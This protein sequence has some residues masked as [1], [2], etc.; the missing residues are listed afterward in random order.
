MTQT[1][2][3]A[4]D[5]GSDDTVERLGR[6]ALVT[7][8]ILYLVVGVL[9]VQVAN[10]DADAKASQ[11][12]A[13]ESI[14]HQSHGRILLVVLL[15][16]LVAHALWR[17]ALAVRGEE[18]PD[19]DSKSVAK[20]VANVGRSLVYVSFSV[21]AA[22]IVLS[23]GGNGGGGGGGGKQEQESTATVLS[24][25]GG[26]WL[27]VGA[28]VVGLGVGVWNVRKVF[29]RSYMEDLDVSRLDRRARRGVEVLGAAGYAA[30]GFAFALVGWFLI[31]AGRQRD[32]GETRS[33][34]AALRELTT[35]SYGPTL[36]LLLA[37]GLVLFGAFRILDGLLRRPTELTHS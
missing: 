17:L 18:G 3:A 30:R 27:V 13:I 32:P 23:D 19:E 9:A 20:R 25:T 34:D 21:L 1:S 24:W 4:S 2:T 11:R 7:Q 14:A 12:G 10:G 8:G 31:D 6:G 16:G 36:L 15:V 26:S 5:V 28:G 37:V 35:A 29:T 22:R 33:L